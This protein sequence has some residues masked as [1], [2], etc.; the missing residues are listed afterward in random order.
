MDKELYKI[1]LNKYLTQYQYLNNLLIETK[2]LFDKY[3]EVFLKEYYGDEELQKYKEQKQS[4]YN[5]KQNTNKD[6][7]NDNEEEDSNN[8][9]NDSDNEENIQVLSKLYKKLSLKTHPDKVPDKIDLFKKISLAYKQRDLITLINIAYQLQMDIT[10]LIDMENESV[11]NILNKNIDNIN[12]EINDL[13]NT[14]AW[15]WA[16]ASE[17]DKQKYK[18][19][20][21][22]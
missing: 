20:N 3:N 22:I 8:E 5:K 11:I 13:Q 12:K 18:E 7:D 6:K 10:N 4:E 21:K 17:D 14:V 15:H 19:Q 9:D 16:H 2:Y 1:R